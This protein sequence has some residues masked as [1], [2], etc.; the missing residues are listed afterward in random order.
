MI[1]PMN[2]MLEK[3]IAQ[4]VSLSEDEQELL[5]SLMIKEMEEGRIRHSVKRAIDDPAPSIDAAQ[6]F[7]E[8]RSRLRAQDK[9]RHPE[10]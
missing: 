1:S 3:A 2:K 8:A 7:A 6:V 5:A 4:A 10:H 9:N